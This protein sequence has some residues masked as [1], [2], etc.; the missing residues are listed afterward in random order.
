MKV[1][2]GETLVRG[3][4]FLGGHLHKLETL[5]IMLKKITST[6]P[7]RVVTKIS[8]CRVNGTSRWEIKKLGISFG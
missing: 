4:S 1:C 2:K 5:A 6:P 7:F 8:T 3:K